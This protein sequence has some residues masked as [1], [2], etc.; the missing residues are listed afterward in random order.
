M[1]IVLREILSKWFSDRN[2]SF[3]RYFHSLYV[4]NYF[5]FFQAE[6]GIRDGHVTG[7]QTCALPISGL[8]ANPG[9]RQSPFCGMLPLPRHRPRS[10]PEGVA[11]GELIWAV[12]D[13][14]SSRPRTGSRLSSCAPGPSRGTT[15]SSAH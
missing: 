8:S 10:P 12:A 4:Y 11:T 15:S 3:I 1:L 7:V 13:A 14:A 5:F 9:W 6:D 2:F